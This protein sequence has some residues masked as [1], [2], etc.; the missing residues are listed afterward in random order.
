MLLLSAVI[1]RRVY[2]PDGRMVGRIADLA[3]RMPGSVEPALV[4]RIVVHRRHSR[5]VLVPWEV[6]KTVAHSNVRLKVDVAESGGLRTDDPL[7]TDEI[8]LV[9]DVLDTQVFD[10][11][12]QRLSRVGDVVLAHRDH[13][14]EVVGVEVGFGAVLRRLGLAR[15]VE[16]HPIDLLPWTEVHLTSDRGHAVQLGSPRSAIHR[17]DTRGLAT[18]IAR[19]DTDSA[20][21]VLATKEDDVTADV[22]QRSVP[23]L[24]ERMLRAMGGARA[25]RVVAAMPA[26]HAARWR[27]ILSTPRVLRRRHFL[28]SGVWPRRLLRGERR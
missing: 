9:R 21:E 19:L 25:A 3:V 13:K 5:D 23:L 18:L 12:G 20:A 24:G 7:G 16:R 27:A 2:S 22:I 10:I 26:H 28:R 17:L 4:D 14:M 6:V 11:V 1:G 15:V 8:L